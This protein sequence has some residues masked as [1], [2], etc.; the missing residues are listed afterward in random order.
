MLT[1]FAM[2][3]MAR[4][5]NPSAYFVCP[6]SPALHRAINHLASSPNPA[7]QYQIKHAFTQL[8]QPHPAHNHLMKASHTS[9]AS[10][11]LLASADQNPHSTIPKRHHSPAHQSA[12][13]VEDASLFRVTELKHDVPE[14]HLFRRAKNFPLKKFILSTYLFIFAFQ[15]TP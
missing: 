12:Y 1:F 15:D 4:H 8:P 5:K 7:H 13:S 3:Y 9:P 14:I 6:H 2:L 10:A 11:S